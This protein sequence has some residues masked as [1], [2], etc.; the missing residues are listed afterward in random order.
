[1][2]KLIGN[3]KCYNLRNAHHGL[4]NLKP[5][6]IFSLSGAL[7]KEYRPV[8]IQQQITIE[9]PGTYLVKTYLTGGKVNVNKIVKL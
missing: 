9:N 4:S 6:E 5:I 3:R 2:Y 8:D 7:I 1:M